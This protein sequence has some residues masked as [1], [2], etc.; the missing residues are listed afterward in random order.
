MQS[1][2]YISFV[3]TKDRSIDVKTIRGVGTACDKEAMG[4]VSVMP[5]WKPG[6]E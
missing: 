5:P 1:T 4:V 6:K 3:V 2:V